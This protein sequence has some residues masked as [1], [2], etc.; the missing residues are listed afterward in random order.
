MLGFI[1]GFVFEIEKNE[2]I[3]TIDTGNIGY[4][5]LVPTPSDFNQNDDVFLY[6]HVVFSEI[7]QRIFGF[8]HKIELNIFKQLI[9]I[10]GIGPK[11]ALEVISKFPESSFINVMLEDHETAVKEITTV[12]GIGKKSAETLLISVREKLILLDTNKKL[13][14]KIET[15][16]EN[17]EI[18]DLILQVIG[19]LGYNQK[20]VSKTFQEWFNKEESHEINIKNFLKWKIINS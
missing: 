5:V 11:T 12:K 1:K 20:D 18:P 9:L 15:K 7:D 2:K 8:K 17:N 14:K 4:N 6:S 16:K 13:N 10:S 3:L 19:N